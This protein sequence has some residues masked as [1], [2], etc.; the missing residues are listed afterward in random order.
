MSDQPAF[1]I[2]RVYLPVAAEDGR[3]VL[4]DRLWP[5]GLRKSEAA[6]DDWLK[7]VAPSTELRKW[8]HHDP[9]HWEDFRQRY[10]AEL[11]T[12]PAVAQLRA[13]AADQ[14]VTL[15]YAAHNEEQNHALVLVDYLRSHPETFK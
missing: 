14:P 5:R 13:L 12:N 1:S 4:V 3:R 7:E 2:K 8:F 11:A 15:L 6:I 9:T 10:W